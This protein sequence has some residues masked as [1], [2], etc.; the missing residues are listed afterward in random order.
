VEIQN[1]TTVLADDLSIDAVTLVKADV[2][3]IYLC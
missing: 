1:N 2:P 3:E